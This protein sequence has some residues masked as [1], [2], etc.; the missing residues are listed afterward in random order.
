M[1]VPI[2]RIPILSAVLALTWTPALQSQTTATTDP[3]GF[4]TLNVAAPE[5]GATTFSFRSLGLTQEIAYQ[6]SAER[7]GNVAGT[8]RDS[9]TDNE[10]TW[11]AN[12]FNPVGATAGTATHYVEIVRPTGS[13]NAA[14][15]EG[16]TYD[17]L[18]TDAATKT[19]TLAQNLA[20]GVTQGAI[21]KVRKHWTIASV[22]G[23]N[24]TAGLTGGTA[25]T[26]DLILVQSGQSNTYSTYFYQIGGEGTG[27]RLTTASGADASGKV[28]YPDE[29]LIIKKSQ[30]STAAI[31]LVGGVKMGVSSVPVLPGKNLL[32]NV[33][34]APMTLASSN[35]YTG[36]S[37]TGLAAGSAA[38]ADQVLIYNGAGY[39]IYYFET[40]NF[41]NPSGGWK[42]AANPAQ[43]G[44]IG[45][46]VVPVGT[47]IIVKR[48]GAAGFD[49]K[50]PQHPAVL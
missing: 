36:N 22:F 8:T 12:Q 13:Q 38:S 20:T 34:A 7:V 14:P 37:S 11:T 40:P 4:I 17:I 30:G 9:V 18:A 6:G 5:S 25:E 3:V 31:V 26:A 33:F 29:G 44:D 42:N 28:L 47:G 1:I 46:V 41:L 32:G 16:T 19:I 35:I 39:D 15:G 45:Q 43:T 2:S 21:F 10:A 50:V 27:W 49:W 24:N 48:N 23:A